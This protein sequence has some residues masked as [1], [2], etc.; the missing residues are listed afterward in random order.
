MLTNSTVDRDVSS[1]P[2]VT[3]A[4]TSHGD[5][6]NTSMSVPM[7]I[8]VSTSGTGHRRV[9]APAAATIAA[10]AS[11]TAD[12]A[13]AGNTGSAST[14]HNNAVNASR[15]GPARIRNRRSQPRTVA[16]DR[17]N[18]AAIRRCPE[19]C[20]A[21]TSAAPITATVSAR[22]TSKLTGS[23]TWV[24]P[25]P[26]QRVRRGRSRRRTSPTSRTTRTRA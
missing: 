23:S 17:P 20:A 4:A 6:V 19:P 15:N 7:G 5:T 3:A 12:P 26:A 16:S 1:R 2:D 9:T 25:H 24:R 14:A 22:L 10:T 21:R 18:H 8:P 13:G 11:A